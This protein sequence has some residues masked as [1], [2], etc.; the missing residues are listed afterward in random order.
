[1]S[2]FIP[3]EDINDPLT[4]SLGLSGGSSTGKTFSALR[5]ARGIAQEK[6]GDG[7]RIGFVDTE[8]C[9]ALYY[10]DDFPELVHY[11]MQAVDDS[12]K[13]IGYAPE[14]WAEV[15][16][17]A[18][19]AGFPV[20]VIDSFSHAWEGVGGILDIHAE[21]LNGL[22]GGN[23]DRADRLN[24]L[25][26]AK[27][28]PRW[29]RLVDRIVR[30]KVDLILCTRATAVPQKWNE[31]QGREVNAFNT[32]TRRADVPW[33]PKMDGDLMFEMTAMMVLD[34]RAP[35]CPYFQIK[36]PDQ[37]TGIFDASR[38]MDE[39]TGRKLAQWSISQGSGVARKAILDAA[40]E[41][42][43]GGKDALQKHYK[44]LS[45]PDKATVWADIEA[46]KAIAIE[47]DERASSQ[48]GDLF[49]GEEPTEEEREAAMRLAEEAAIEA[50]KQHTG[51]Q[52]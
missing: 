32:K 19:A 12:G 5:I 11:D 6:G 20:V 7:A 51:D 45:D 13:T 41:A 33:N 23:K 16:D 8:N 48:D 52:E 25:A 31:A 21:T 18:E 46:I 17:E 38:P 43:R 26:W 27:T 1:M 14:R 2:R 9:R 28:K 4:I 3:V 15:I 29:K 50:R 10:Q 39:E 36:Q 34:P 44:S 40:R 22:T 24:M 42:A 30:A 49:A 47:A 35:G 37:I